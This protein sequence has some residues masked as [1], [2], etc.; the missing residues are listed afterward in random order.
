MENKKIKGF[1]LSG[2]KML[3]TYHDNNHEL[4][5]EIIFQQVITYLNS[6]QFKIVNYYLVKETEP[7]PDIKYYNDEKPGIHYHFYFEIEH[8]IDKNRTI[9]IRDPLFFDMNRDDENLRIHGNYITIAN[10]VRNNKENKFLTYDID[11]FALS[12]KEIIKNNL[13]KQTLTNSHRTILYLLKQDRN[14]YSNLPTELILNLEKLRQSLNPNENNELSPLNIIRND[15]F[16]IHLEQDLSTEDNEFEENSYEIKENTKLIHTIDNDISCLNTKIL[17]KKLEQIKKIENIDQLKLLLNGNQNKICI[18]L[19]DT[20]SEWYDN[21]VTELETLTKEKI[22]HK[23]TKI[24][25]VEDLK[26]IIKKN[27]KKLKDKDTVLTLCI[28]HEIDEKECNELLNDITELTKFINFSSGIKKKKEFEVIFF[29][30]LLNFFTSNEKQK[31]L[32]NFI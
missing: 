15:N 7:N 22:L 11:N 14:P 16:P 20:N 9:D 26:E 13:K 18:I 8:Q 25:W 1:R 21:L 12:S 17:S 32:Y 28:D 3:F 19:V 23:T 2:K 29:F 4:N 24:D 30:D 5:K 6:V 31:M 10:I 27:K